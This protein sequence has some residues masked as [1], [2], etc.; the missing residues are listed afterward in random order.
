MRGRPARVT[1]WKGMCVMAVA[2]G[3]A[4]KA[5]LNKTALAAVK[6]KQGAAAGSPPAKAAPAKKA[7]P[8]AKA[9]PAKPTVHVLGSK[10]A[11][12]GK[13][14]AKAAPAKAPAKAAAKAAAAKPDAELTAQER[15]V[16]AQRAEAAEKAKQTAAESLNDERQQTC[17]GPC[18]ET[19]SIRNF[20]TTTRRADGSLGRGKVCRKCRDEKRAAAK[21][22]GK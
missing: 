12:A 8:A 2:R 10:N 5:A 16:K 15:M 13:A 22:S 3:A 20:P 11:T 21:A 6:E 19:K 4:A 18:K 1:R 9:A 14:P 7:A 17:E